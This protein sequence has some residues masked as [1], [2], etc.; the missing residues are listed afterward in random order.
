M[1]LTS[2]TKLGPYEIQSP[3]GA[4]GMGEVYRARDTRLDRIVAIK[5]LHTH[6]SENPDQRQR[7][8]REARAISSLS[9]AHICQ[10]FD[11]GTQDGTD[12]LVMEFLEGETLADRL[13]KG[14][15]P[16]PELLKIGIN[17]AEALEVAHRAGIIHRDLK[18]GNIMLTKSGAR[19]MDFGLAKSQTAIPS[20]SKSSGSNSPATA[21]HTSSMA[22][23]EISA[24]TSPASPLTQKGSIVGTFQYMAPEVLQ[25]GAADARSDIFSFGCVLYEMATGTRAFDAKSQVGVLAAILEK[26]PEPITVSQPA[27]PP[28]L[29]RLIRNCLA[30][31]PDQRWQSAHDLKV[32]L[33]TTADLGSQF[34]AQPTSQ[35]GVPAVVAA[36]QKKRRLLLGALAAGWA[37]A[38]LAIVAAL[39]YQRHANEATFPVHADIDL[40]P[41]IQIHANNGAP[42]L[43]P[44]GSKLVFVGYSSAFSSL[45][46]R[47]LKTGAVTSL[48]GTEQPIFPFWS[49]DS[50]MLGFFANGKL[51]TIPA[52]G[53]AVQIICPALA[54]RGGSWNSSGTIIFTPNIRESIYQVSDAGGTPTA[55]TKLDAGHYTHRNPI[56]LPDGK[57]FLFIQ[58]LEENTTG[59]LYVGSLDA[60][61]P[62]L[63][64]ARA[65]NAAF[66]HGYLLFLRDRNLVAQR[67]DPS[68]FTVSGNPIPIAQ[69]LEYWPPRDLG[70]FSASANGTLTY[71]SE[72]STK[73]RFAWVQLPGNQVEEFGDPINAL[74]SQVTL[75]PNGRKIAYMRRDPSS[76]DGELWVYDLDRKTASRI[77]DQSISALGSAFSPDSSRIAITKR[78]T[79][80]SEFYIRSLSTG[81]EEKLAVNLPNALSIYSWTPDGKYLI[82]AVQ[83]PKTQQDI[84]AQPV[85]GGKA[86]P[87]LTQP[88]SEVGG[89]VSPNGK[90]MAYASDESGRNEL[91]VTDFPGVH[92]K[93]QVSTEGA[94]WAAWAH[95]GKRLYF[96]HGDTLYAAN[97]PNPDTLEFGNTETITTLNGVNPIAIAPDGRL[98]VQRDANG[99]PLQ[100]VLNLPASLPK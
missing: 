36:S 19:L 3:L 21:L 45:W 76:P 74:P 27:A 64:V 48:P 70:N 22:T 78:P 58:R 31:D 86:I 84:W 99:A 96:A 60:S 44:D 83:E 15:I 40:P 1:P 9:H 97:M 23:L 72:S 18:P 75:S 89:T 69:N 91:Y 24:L 34:S 4:G 68:S 90:W 38:F 85:D 11:I 87:L 12:F 65:S 30:K 20:I 33:Q 62:K 61:T 95:D 94:S 47:D 26:D 51:R 82:L 73:D 98:L 46:V 54:G 43:S 17:I 16:I 55:V 71:R 53:G 39:Y 25:G 41:G 50:S 5:I 14:P 28:A 52:A 59:D 66:V 81:T 35:L 77:L 10:L 88:Y 57:H 100:I 42:T 32:Q 49:P 80:T 29:D 7:F 79:A 2:G 37:L 92:A 13:R 8:E 6:L 56:F 93:L 63:V 67:F